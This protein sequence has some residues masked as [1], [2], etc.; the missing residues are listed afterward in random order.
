MVCAVSRWT[1]TDA[2]RGD[3]YDARWRRLAASGAD[4]HGEADLVDS[5]LREHGG[6]TRVLD[7]GCGT[8]RIAIELARRGYE[9]VGVDLDSRMLDAARAKAPDLAW[10]EA[11]LAT[12]A[13]AGRFDA[14]VLAGNVVIFLE[15]GSEGPVL[16]TLSAQLDPGGLLVAGFQV[17]PDR[18]S[19]AEYD[20]LA[21]A[22]GL[23]ALVRWSTWDRSPYT[24]GDYAVTVHQRR[25]AL[26]E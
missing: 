21:G 4:V 17:R 8:G 20:R 19:L 6:G 3:D 23:E 24:G 5:L 13:P 14:A 11:D 9:V 12:M 18:L 1:G 2:P 10:V 22:A 26:Q 16:S 25:T 15:P 7:A